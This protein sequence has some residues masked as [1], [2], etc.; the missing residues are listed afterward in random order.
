MNAHQR[1]KA[2]RALGIRPPYTCIW[3]HAKVLAIGKCPGCGEMLKPIGEVRVMD[4]AGKA[5]DKG[6][7]IDFKIVD[8]SLEEGPEMEFVDKSQAV[9]EELGVSHEEAEELR[10]KFWEENFLPASPADADAA[11]EWAADAAMA[12]A[13]MEE[14]GEVLTHEQVGAEL[15]L[16]DSEGDA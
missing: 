15:G 11:G 13:A 10:K 5:Y 4:L 7:R 9:C 2:R 3:C 6:L 14:D 12:E 16:L 1:R 8:P